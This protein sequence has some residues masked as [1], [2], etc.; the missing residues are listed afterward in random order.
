VIKG[1]GPLGG[2]GG[3]MGNGCTATITKCV[4]KENRAKD[5]AGIYDCDGLIEHNTIHDNEAVD[6]Q[7]PGGPIGDIGIGGGLYGCDGII[8]NN[9]I[10]KN[11]AFAGGGLVFCDAEI[12]NNPVIGNLAVW[13]GALYE[14][15]GIIR[16]CSIVANR[17]VALESCKGTITN[18]IIW[19]SPFQ[20]DDCNVPSY[21][22][23]ENW[24]GG[25]EGNIDIDPEFVD[26]NNGDYHLKSEAG[27]W[28]AGLQEW[29]VDSV[30]SPCIDAGD[31][32]SDYCGELWPH[33][34]RINM[35]AYGG[36]SEASMS[37][38]SVGSAA[39]M[40][41]DDGVDL[42][43]FG[44]LSSE[45]QKEEVLLREDIDRDG[46]VS[47]SDLVMFCEEWMM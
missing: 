1:R 40:N 32:G 35:G 47:L 39:D 33:G 44:E 21:C 30:T 43:D 34:G 20:F 29:V 46:V 14:C 5:G 19:Q 38:S 9:T 11:F 18:C 7:I 15:H 2:G 36:T 45:W 8:V 23:I 26:P 10:S 31:P 24:L 37:L 3:I 25:G 12:I 22:C 28:D 41:C 27:R 17:N 13:G 4:V 16:N 6:I 42:E